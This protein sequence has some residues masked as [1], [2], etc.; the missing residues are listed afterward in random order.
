MNTDDMIK[1]SNSY[2]NRLKVLLVRDKKSQTVNHFF[3]NIS[4]FS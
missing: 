2:F 3:L 1:G 4:R